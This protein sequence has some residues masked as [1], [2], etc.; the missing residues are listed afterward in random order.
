[1]ATQT[2]RTTTPATRKPKTV[3]PYPERFRA[4]LDEGFAHIHR[5]LT[6]AGS[7]TKDKGLLGLAGE[8]EKLAAKW[9]A[10]LRGLQCI[11]K[12]ESPRRGKAVGPDLEVG[13]KL[14]L[15]GTDY[16]RASLLHGEKVAQAPVEVVGSVG[17]WVKV[18]LG[19][20]QPAAVTSRMLTRDAEKAKQAQ[21]DIQQGLGPL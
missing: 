9:K 13:A 7:Q 5:A 21:G 1:M 2:T 16:E 11:D 18:K 6:H 20:G 14:Y 10:P 12:L 15:L 8:V 4:L 17:S 19:N 3:R